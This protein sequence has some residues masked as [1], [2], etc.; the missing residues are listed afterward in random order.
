M[1]RG[2]FER[3]DGLVLPNNITQFGIQTILELALRNT[4]VSFYV[5]LCN[6]V[7]AP[8]LNVAD[9]EEPTIGAN[10]YARIAVTRD[11]TGWPNVGTINN[12]YYMQTDFL[13]WA[14]TPAAFD[15]SISRMFICLHATSLVVD[16]FAL[17]AAL[18]DE[19][20]IG[21]LTDESDRKFRY[22]IFGH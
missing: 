22:S 15:Q 12:E 2:Q 14:A 21:P 11:E 8:D 17:S 9:I 19:I 7:Y 1:L 13:T 10:G 5:G 6:A 20:L 3:A 16:V 18:P 4:S